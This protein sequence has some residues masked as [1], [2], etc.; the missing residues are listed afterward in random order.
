[1]IGRILRNLFGSKLTYLEILRTHNFDLARLGSSGHLLCTKCTLSL[2]M[3]TP[4]AHART[5]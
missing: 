5:P 4:R 2:L 3:G 1:M